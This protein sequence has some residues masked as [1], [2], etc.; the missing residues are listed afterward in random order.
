[1]KLF[2]FFL[3]TS[4]CV[5]VGIASMAAQASILPFA[6]QENTAYSG[7]NGPPCM[8]V[9]SATI[10]IDSLAPNTHT[11]FPLNPQTSCVINK[12]YQGTIPIPPSLQAFCDGS[13]HNSYPKTGRFNAIY[14]PVADSSPSPM[15]YVTGVIPSIGACTTTVQGEN[16]ASLGGKIYS[17]NQSTGVFTVH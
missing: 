4:C 9:N 17:C 6:A 10:C 7:S 12:N 8:G 16:L 1:M 3:K 14:V 13:F 5:V 2:N 15:F 11:K